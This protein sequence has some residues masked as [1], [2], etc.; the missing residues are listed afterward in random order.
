MKKRI[1]GKKQENFSLR[2][3]TLLNLA[4]LLYDSNLTS[5]HFLVQF[6]KKNL[7]GYRL[8]ILGLG[9]KIFR[10]LFLRGSHS[11]K[12]LVEKNQFVR[13]PNQ[14]TIL[15]HNAQ[16]FCSA[17]F[18]LLFLLGYKFQPLNGRGFFRLLLLLN[19]P[20]KCLLR[21]ISKLGEI[22]PV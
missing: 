5:D 19:N 9:Q 16:S 12:K 7:Y 8:I 11:W 3:R 1:E 20:A 15:T 21:K 4:C 13:G 10:S 6:C 18:N 14:S 17:F 2:K 22:A